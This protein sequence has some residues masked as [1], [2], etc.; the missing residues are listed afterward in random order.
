MQHVQLEG[1]G[2]FCLP[3][4]SGY[5]GLEAGLHAELVHIRL[6]LMD[7]RELTIP[8]A[9]MARERLFAEFHSAHEHSL[10]TGNSD[11]P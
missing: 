8:I 6:A 9:D 2:P 10:R 1:E 3:A 11:K 4:V 7:G 5:L